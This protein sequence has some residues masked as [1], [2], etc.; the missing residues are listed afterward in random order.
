MF[1]TD[2]QTM[3]AIY[4]SMTGKLTRVWSHEKFM[5]G[6]ADLENCQTKSGESPLLSWYA[7]ASVMM[8]WNYRRT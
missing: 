2:F 3:E 8:T 4:R 1:P 7:N 6:W 5:R